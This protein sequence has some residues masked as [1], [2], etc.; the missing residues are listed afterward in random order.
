VVTGL[1]AHANLRL[2]RARR[3]LY[4]TTDWQQLGKEKFKNCLQ[5][6]CGR[7]GNES[8]K[9]CLSNVPA[10]VIKK[11]ADYCAL[12]QIYEKGDKQH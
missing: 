2:W 1:M 11:G 5:V 7:Q 3:C 6:E 8:E 12:F 9:T 10:I 4:F